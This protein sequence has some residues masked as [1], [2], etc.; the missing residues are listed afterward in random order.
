MFVSNRK[1]GADAVVLSSRDLHGIARTLAVAQPGHDDSIDRASHH[2]EEGIE[3]LIRYEVLGGRFKTAFNDK[4]TWGRLDPNV[5][6]LRASAFV[7][8]FTGMK[9]DDMLPKLE[10]NW[11][12]VFGDFRDAKALVIDVSTNTGGAGFIP[13][14]IARRIVREPKVAL[15]ET[16][17][18]TA[19]C[20]RTSS[21]CASSH[22]PRFGLPVLS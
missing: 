18:E 14:A 9:R 1:Q 8:L 3:A 12:E 5:A 4:L 6:Y 13:N 16:R 10:G 17:S 7:G 20:P 21:R 19:D 11:D 22:P 2:I 15:D